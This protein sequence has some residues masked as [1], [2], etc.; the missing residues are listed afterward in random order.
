MDHL[1]HQALVLEQLVCPPQDRVHQSL[2]LRQRGAEE[3]QL[4]EGELGVAGGEPSSLQ[5]TTPRSCL[6][7]SSSP[8]TTSRP[9]PG[10]GT[11]VRRWRAPFDP[12]PESGTKVRRW[13]APFDLCPESGTKV[14]R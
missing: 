10:I 9:C 8:A 12:C 4:S 14:R 13:R 7:E 2:G 6:S 11:K 5:I 1:V 3:Q